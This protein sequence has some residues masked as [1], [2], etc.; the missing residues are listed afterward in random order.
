MIIYRQLLKVF[1]PILKIKLSLEK[2]DDKWNVLK[3]SRW[4]KSLNISPN[5]H[6]F[7]FI[8]YA[9]MHYSSSSCIIYRQWQQEQQNCWCYCFQK[10]FVELLEI[11]QC[12]SVLTRC[13][14]DMLKAEIDLS[15]D[16][17]WNIMWD[18]TYQITCCTHWNVYQKRC[19][20]IF[21]EKRK[22]S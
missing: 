18:L 12:W 5:K 4:D 2:T 20:S 15:L 14:S 9:L 22:R 11:P 7:I 13:H 17:F 6:I 8:L 21:N 16:L 10:W 19:R 1:C 3:L